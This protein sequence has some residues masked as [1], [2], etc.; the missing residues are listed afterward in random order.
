[1]ERKK[2]LII[3]M[4]FIGGGG[5]EKNLYIITNHLSKKIKNLYVCT[6]SNSK[7]K[8]FNRKIKFIIPKSK[9]SE[10]FTIRIK[11]LICLFSLF[12]FLIKNRNHDNIVFSLQANIYC[13]LLCKIFRLKIIVRSN[14]SPSGW[15]HNS[16]K[17]II[18]KTIIN[19]ADSVITNSLDFKKEMKKLFS[20][21]SVCIYNPLNKKEIIRKS[22]AEVKN[23]FFIKS[24]V[25][26]ILNVGRLTKQKDQLTLLRCAKILMNKNIDFKI[27]IIGSGIEKKTLTEFIFNNKLKK[28]VKIVPFNENPFPHFRRCN[29]FILSSIYEG[30]PNVLLEAATLKKF[31][32]SSNCPTGPKEILDNGKGGLLFRK[33]NYQDLCKKIIIFKENKLRNKEKINH[34]YKRLNRFEYQKNLKKYEEVIN[35]FF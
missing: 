30:L 8:K 20:V 25:L 9:F 14:S 31:I 7:K 12:K 19:W 32:I 5:V 27:L 34:C 1:M 4:P 29:L 22:K 11:Y 23:N 28:N 17:K 10:N 15:Y 35:R 13:I 6:I 2:N 24:C 18:Y 33:G 26:N 21:K 3:F 16:I